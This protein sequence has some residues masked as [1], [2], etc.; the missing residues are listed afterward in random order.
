MTYGPV[1]SFATRVGELADGRMQQRFEPFSLLGVREDPLAQLLAIQSAV[2]VLH[3]RA[4][5]AGDL[6]KQRRTWRD[7]LAREH[8]RV[9]N[10]HSERGKQVG[11]GALAGGDAAGEAD[12]KARAHVRS[13]RMRVQREIPVDG[14]VAR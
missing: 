7:D 8:V 12:A 5:M 14:L 4:E 11:D 9:D 13:A 2:G 1:R 6:T 10:R 3:L